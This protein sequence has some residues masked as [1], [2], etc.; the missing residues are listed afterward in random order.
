MG[1]KNNLLVKPSRVS[2]QWAAALLK[3]FVAFELPVV[4][5]SPQVNSAADW[6]G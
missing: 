6:G 1:A 2:K 4:A 5:E 3:G